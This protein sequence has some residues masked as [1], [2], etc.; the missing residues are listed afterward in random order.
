[1][2]T[3]ETRALIQRYYET[4]STGDEAAIGK[5]LT[6]DCE[7]LP[8]VAAPMTAVKG[9]SAVAEQFAGTLVRAPSTFANL[10]AWR[11]AT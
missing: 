9:G 10:S 7:W 3:E 11:S 1:M 6:D 5:L 8:P 2:K 4:L